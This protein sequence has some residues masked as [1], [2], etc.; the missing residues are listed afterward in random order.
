MKMMIH[1]VLVLQELPPK[2][3]TFLNAIGRNSASSEHVYRIGLLHFQQF[4]NSR[5]TNQMS[6]SLESVLSPL[7]TQE[8]NVYELFDQ[9]VSFLLQKDLSTKS[10]TLYVAALRSYLAYYDIDIVSSKFKRKVKIPK[11]FREDEEP[12]D[13]ADIRNLLLK[14]NRKLKAYILVLA[15]SGL[16]AME[17][18]KT[19]W[20]NCTSV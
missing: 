19:G 6:Y 16:R 7:Q 11:H 15:S 20:R 17:A 4:L 18:C 10:L 9:F 14:C 1:N 2:A 13:G 3:R 12:L 5:Y 8:I